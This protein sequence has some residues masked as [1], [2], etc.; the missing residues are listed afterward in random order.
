MRGKDAVLWT[1]HALPYCFNGVSVAEE[2]HNLAGV[3]AVVAWLLEMKG[4]P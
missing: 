1:L 3:K 2:K 4:A